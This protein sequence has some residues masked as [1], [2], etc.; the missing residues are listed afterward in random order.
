MQVYL[1]LTD[2]ENCLL[3]Q[4]RLTNAFYQG[5]VKTNNRQ[6]PID[7]VV[8]QAGQMAPSA[9]GKVEHGHPVANALREFHEETGIDLLSG[10]IDGHQIEISGSNIILPN[11]DTTWIDSNETSNQPNLSKYH[12]Q[13]YCTVVLQVSKETLEFIEKEANNNLEVYR[14][15]SESEGEDLGK[16]AR[17]EDDSIKIRRPAGKEVEDWELYQLQKVK[18]EDIKDKLGVS[19]D[20]EKFVYS[21]LE[22]EK[23]GQGFISGGFEETDVALEKLEKKLEREAK[24]RG[25]SQSID[26]YKSIGEQITNVHTDTSRNLAEARPNIG[27]IL[28]LLEERRQEIKDRSIPGDNTHNTKHNFSRRL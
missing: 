23:Q 9:G 5:R 4:K 7:S 1:I 28:K 26:W 22:T 24:G 17:K 10:E 11:G 21:K 3:S 2:G 6:E 20:V 12:G 16:R 18:N 8:N 15:G 14:S 25:Y 27:N 13:D 19:V